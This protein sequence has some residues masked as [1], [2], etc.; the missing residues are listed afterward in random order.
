MIDR[1]VLIHSLNTLETRFLPFRYRVDDAPVWPLLRMGLGG[2][3]LRPEVRQARSSGRSP[4][5]R[6]ADPA[7]I[8]DLFGLTKSLPSSPLLFLSDPINW[9]DTS[10]GTVDKFAHPLITA[11]QELGLRS[12]LMTSEEPE[13]PFQKVPGMRVIRKKPLE[14]LLEFAHW[15][16]PRTP[17]T[18]LIKDSVFWDAVISD[19]GEGSMPML[20][21][22][23]H[24][25]RFRLRASFRMMD[26]IRPSIV[27][28]SCWYNS[29][30]MAIA[31]VSQNL[32][33]P[34]VDIQHGVQGPL[35]LAYGAWRGMPKEG[36]SSI[37]SF[38]WCWDQA[39]AD[40]IRSWAPPGHHQ[41]FVGGSPW[42]EGYPSRS[43][44]DRAVV[45][46]RILISLQPLNG[47][48]PNELVK[49]IKRSPST[50]KWVFRLHPSDRN[51]R[52][53]LD[54][55]SLDQNIGDRI[56]V[57]DPTVVPIGLSL[58]RTLLHVTSYSS[59]IREA[60]MVG[61]R[62]IAWHP[63]AAASYPDLV[64]DGSLTCSLKPLISE[65]PLE[66]FFVPSTIQ[67]P[68]PLSSRLDSFL[69][70]IG[71]KGAHHGAT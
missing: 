55:W 7:R 34:S 33:I 49:A 4:Q 14:K 53:E 68:S 52:S 35:H 8:F 48:L 42:L 24:D 56:E 41:P 6:T 10:L 29:D 61:V 40:N 15:R 26:R 20:A 70:F 25:H 46:D 32:G 54:L 64:Q 17:M 21:D 28:Y 3:S 38:F 39:S 59:V 16:I 65:D 36:C 19:F 27:F 62:S 69:A 11:A 18:E 37:P 31:H 43:P 51:Y 23:V 30:H 50:I 47:K 66:A 44:F 63:D 5:A 2:R 71:H 58:M 60:A 22:A 13:I 9:A 57:E 45:R 12:I 67:P 1:N